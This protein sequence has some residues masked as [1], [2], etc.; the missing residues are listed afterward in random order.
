M[1][2]DVNETIRKNKGLVYKQLHKFSLVDDADANSYG[3]EALYRAIET[4][5][6]ESGVKFSTYASVCIYNALGCYV[7][8]LKNKRQIV[9]VSYN[10]VTEEGVEFSAFISSKSSVEDD[11]MNRMRLEAV[12]RAMRKLKETYTDTKLDVFNLWY[13]SE[14]TISSVDIAKTLG[15]SQP[16]AYRL[17]SYIRADIKKEIGD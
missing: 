7:R 8:K 3:F 13:D 12:Y 5:K 17:L 4:Y 16:Y 14:F 6:P 2:E 1:T 9:T 11:A 10:K 15:I